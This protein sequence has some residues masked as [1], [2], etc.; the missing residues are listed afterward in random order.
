VA[1]SLP[2]GSANKS[3]QPAKISGYA[4][5]LPSFQIDIAKS[6]EEKLGNLATALAFEKVGE[7][8]TWRRAKVPRGDGLVGISCAHQTGY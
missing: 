8:D 3:A 1:E 5:R 2:L 6:I 7:V 4:N